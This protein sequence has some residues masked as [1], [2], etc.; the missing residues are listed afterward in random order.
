M[1]IALGILSAVGLAFLGALATG[2][3]STG[4]VD[5]QLRGISLARTYLEEINSCPFAYSY[6]NNPD[7]PLDSITVPG[8]F[9]VTILTECSNDGSSWMPGT[10]CSTESLVRVTANLPVQRRGCDHA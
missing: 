1:I 8:Q 6:P 2:S 9:Q 5:E 7:C 3:R 10:F 4:I